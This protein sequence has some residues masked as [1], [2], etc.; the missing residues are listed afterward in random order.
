[1]SPGLARSNAVPIAVRRSGMPRT[2]S[3]RWR[4]AISAPRTISSTIAAAFERAR[5]GAVV[6]LA[7]KGHEPTILYAD[8]A[9]PWD[10]AAVAREALAQLGFGGG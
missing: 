2:S 6:L 8:R 5:L 1:M 4:P 9:M 3:P 7:G 10:E